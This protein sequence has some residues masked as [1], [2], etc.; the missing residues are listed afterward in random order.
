MYLCRKHIQIKRIPPQ[1]QFTIALS[2]SDQWHGWH[3]NKH[4]T[5]GFICHYV[6]TR[7]V[8]LSVPSVYADHSSFS[9][10]YLFFC[11]WET[12]CGRQLQFNIVQSRVLILKPWISAYMIPHLGF[13]SVWNLVSFKMI[14]LEAF[15]WKKKI[16]KILEKYSG[17]QK[18][19]YIEDINTF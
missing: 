3:V 6:P 4:I 17:S 14:F 13:F 12:S 9:D 18:S 19:T 10:M 2:S 1:T 11:F 16:N 8:F 5:H 15:H 7:Q